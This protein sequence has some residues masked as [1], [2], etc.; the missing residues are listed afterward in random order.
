MTQPG[1]KQD[2]EFGVMSKAPEKGMRVADNVY[3]G[4]YGSLISH[5][6]K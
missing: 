2:N 3:L 1:R 4:Y 5:T 6:W